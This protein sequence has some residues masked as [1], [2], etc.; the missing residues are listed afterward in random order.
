MMTMMQQQQQQNQQF[1]VQQQQQFFQ[2]FAQ[3]AQAGQAQAVQVQAGPVVERPVQAREVRLPEFAKLAPVFD[4]KSSDPVVAENW[5]TEMEKTFKAFSMPEAMKMPLAE[6]QMKDTANDWWVGQK[7]GQQGEVSW[8][9]F[10][11]MFYRKYFPQSTRDTM[12]SR[13]WAL[14]QGNRSVI[15]YEAEFNHLVKFTPPGIRDSEETK[16]QRFRDGLNLELQH[17]IQGFEMTTL[18]ALVL[19]VK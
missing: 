4:G 13:L 1:L 3:Q 17:D 2:Q 6:F 15:E 5:V 19:K 11:E 9:A 10:K 16:L 14:K 7:A 12:L 8:T 18:G